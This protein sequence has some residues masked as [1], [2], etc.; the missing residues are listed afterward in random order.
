MRINRAR[1]GS[2]VIERAR[3][4]RKNAGRR[5]KGSA[6]IVCEG[7]FTEPYYLKGLLAHFDINSASVEVIAGQTR[8][9]AVAV[10]KRAR[11]RFQLNPRDRV[12]VVID[13]EQADLP[14][15]L[16]LC[17]TPVQRA[18]TRNG[19]PE[20][21]IEP[22]ISAPCFEVWLLLHFRY[23]DQPFI[24][25]ADVLP[26]LQAHLND[27]AK[28]DPYIFIKTGAGAGLTRAMTHAA[29]L[30]ASKLQTG[31]R[32]PATDMDILVKSLRMISPEF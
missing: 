32:I 15:A 1:S 14:R 9:N 17:K 20:I 30:R 21:R 29:R 31:G 5:E 16:Q 26:A 12:F 2:V 4:D 23:C 28:K 27:Y 18:N 25:Y 13:A 10:V 8:S 7:E 22:I 6:L 19:Q 11:D 3:V 24:A